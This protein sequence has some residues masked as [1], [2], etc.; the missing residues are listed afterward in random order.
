LLR[1]ID[2]FQTQE[3]LPDWEAMLGLPGDCLGEIDLSDAD[4]RRAIIQTLNALGGASGLYF[5]QILLN[6]GYVV[7][8]TPFFRPFLSGYA[9][10]G[11]ALTNGETYF[12]SGG[13]KSGDRLYNSGWTH[14]WEVHS[15]DDIVTCFRSGQS[16]SGDRLCVFGNERIECIIRKLKPAQTGVLFT[17][18]P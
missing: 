6:A 13:A 2:P 3:L 16:R 5:E 4:R 1:E 18:G 8:V 12:V 14:W 15:D 11:D 10:S 7:E 17:Y 9:R